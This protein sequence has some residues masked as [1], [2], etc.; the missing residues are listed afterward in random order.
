MG[1]PTESER[2]YDIFEEFACRVTCTL[3]LADFATKGLIALRSN[4]EADAQ[5]PK[6]QKHLNL[7]L[8]I[9]TDFPATW[10]QATIALWSH[11]ETYIED[12]A[13]FILEEDVMRRDM[14]LGNVKVAIV[15][16][17]RADE[18]E[19]AH[20]LFRSLDEEG[21]G[22][23]T[24]PKFER[25]LTRL[26]IK[27]TPA[28]WI[29][30]QIGEWNHVRN[31][32]VHRKRVDGRFR[33]EHPGVPIDYTGQAKLSRDVVA[34]YAQCGIG[35]AADVLRRYVGPDLSSELEDA[36]QSWVDD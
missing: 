10:A 36:I 13:S 33:R 21:K 20:V 22:Q 4:H 1:T 6:T 9:D 3:D 34:A 35:Y 27:G 19:R 2:A 25:V 18:D 23:R 15:D 16:Y 11:L 28:K 14:A 26:G 24:H 8:E 31:N 7:A 5:V 30:D 29:A 12:I 32:L 17:L